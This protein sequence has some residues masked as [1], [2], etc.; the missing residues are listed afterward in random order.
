MD[1]VREPPKRTRRNVIIGAGIAVVLLLTVAVS[2]LESRPPSVEVG[3][4]MIDSVRRG[5]MLRQVRAPGTLEPEH[6]R[7]IS[8]LTAGRIEQLPIRPGARVTPTTELLQL[9][10]PDVQ[11]EAL[12]AQQQLASAQSHAPQSGQH[13]IV[14]HWPVSGTRARKHIAPASCQR[15]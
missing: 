6:V 13:R 3:T 12:T 5:T 15:V 11:L 9:S 1:I 10:N 8:A 2:R 7:F 4:L 14:T